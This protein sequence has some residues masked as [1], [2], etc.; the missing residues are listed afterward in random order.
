MNSRFLQ[1]LL[2]L[3][4]FLWLPLAACST[5]LKSEQPTLVLIVLDT[6][7]ADHLSV[8]GYPKPTSP[9]L[10]AFAKRGTVFD[11]AFSTSTWTLPAHA[12]MFSGLLPVDHRADQ[13][14][15][16]IRGDVPLLAELL[17][18]K[19]FQTAGFVNNPWLSDETGLSGGFEHFEAIWKEPK[20][21]SWWSSGHPTTNKIRRFFKRERDPKRPLFLLV[22]LMEAHGPYTPRWRTAKNFFPNK[23]ALKEARRTN[24]LFGEMGVNQA[25]YIMRSRFTAEIFEKQ[26]ALYDAEVRAAD[27]VT[28]NI[29]SVVDQ[30]C[31]PKSSTILIVSDHGQNFGDHDHAGHIFA[32]YQSTLKVA[33]LA[34]GEG[35]RAGERKPDPVSLTDVFPTL[36]ASAKHPPMAGIDGRDLRAPPD[37]A[38]VLRASFAYPH[39]ALSR[40]SPTQR[41]SEH[42]K[43]NKRSLSAVVDWPFKAIFGSD[44]SREIYDLSKDP[45]ERH[46]LKNP[47]AELQAHLDELS[48]EEPGPSLEPEGA[49]PEL[50]SETIEALRRLGYVQ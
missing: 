35:F 43:P 42:V 6:V 11:Q 7:R 2:L 4:L 46:P 26:R 22:N 29:L 25:W 19:G 5:P 50:D 17:S 18:A 24:Y 8:Y 21:E 40:F 23:A 12:S 44:G 41:L 34:R 49:L 48:L 33:L 39:Q 30:H 27:N 13:D 16:F 20:T 9:F 10:E 45:D 47:S 28:R 31:D 1:N 37:E 36:L 38:R 14:H 3:W 15:L 32:L